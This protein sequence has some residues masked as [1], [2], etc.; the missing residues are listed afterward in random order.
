[1]KYI[2]TIHDQDFLVEII[3]DTHVS[4]NG[5]NYAIDFQTIGDHEFY[6]LLVDGNSYEAF[7][8]PEDEGWQVLLQ[9]NM[10][11]VRVED[12]REKQL[13]LASHNELLPHGEF[14]LKAPMPGLIVSLPVH[15]GQE[16]EKGEVLAILESMKMQN[17]LRSP[18][19]GVVSRLRI[20][21]GDSVEQK[22]TLLSVI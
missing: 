13:R 7:I 2:A 19:A 6:S 5:K 22:Q 8:Y 12:E 10:Y 1:M 9:G 18:R 20:K 15:I 3:D 11:P 16:V 4:V 14:Y 17:E 21:T